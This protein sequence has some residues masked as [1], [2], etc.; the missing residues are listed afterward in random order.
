M[1]QPNESKRYQGHFSLPE[2]GPEGQKRLKASRVL[3]VG[4]GGLGAPIL[5][6]LTASGVGTIGVMDYDVVSESNLL[7]QTLFTTANI[8]SFK[9]SLAVEHL[10]KL[11]PHVKF[12]SCDIAL[13]ETN[14]DE[15]LARYD[16]IVDGTDNFESKHLIN[17][18][19]AKLNKP[20]VSGS[21]FKT[22]GQVSV[23]NFGDGPCYSC[24]YSDSGIAAASAACSE[25]GVLSPLPGIVGSIQAAEAIKI[26]VGFGRPLSGRLLLV[27]A[28]KMEFQ[29][30]R[31][32]KN[33]D[34]PVCGKVTGELP[35]LSLHKKS[36]AP[37][38]SISELIT[39]I[40]TESPLVL[41]ARSSSEFEHSHI[42][43]STPFAPEDVDERELQ[44]FK[45]REIVVY[46]T[47]GVRSSFVQA[48][49]L[50]R[51]IKA[52]VLEGGFNAWRFLDLPSEAS[53]A[54]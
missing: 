42:P 28:M 3:C 36:E 40:N 37:T 31:F 51:G 26:L 17:R 4:A 32:A 22:E 19:C 1:S 29:E 54:R 8:G 44:H 48:W 24:L 46:C 10:S 30:F 34:C 50:A 25:V 27:D 23:F 15:I 11:N 49:L 39:K 7:R 16:L 20:V 9:A 52:T 13:N 43:G 41:D 33:P 53:C 2:I 6:Y 14:A 38:I 21:I 35:K 12:L 47:S 18:I 45:N 5:T